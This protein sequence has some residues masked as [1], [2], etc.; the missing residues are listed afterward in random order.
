V[1]APKHNPEPIP[2]VSLEDVQRM[3]DACINRGW[4]TRRDR[5]AII[6]LFDTGVRRSEFVALNLQDIDMDSGAVQVL[7]GKGSKDRVTFFSDM[8]RVELRRYLRGRSSEPGDRPLWLGRDRERMSVEALRG[9]IEHAA[10]RAGLATVPSPH[11]FRRGFAVNMLR[12]GADLLTVSRLLGHESLEVTKRY[13]ALV[14]DDL[15]RVHKATSPAD[16]LKLRR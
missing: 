4:Y 13:L 10:E 5:A 15:S 3:A 12:N 11:D 8:T 6:F 1:Q 2:G 16:R 14:E 9:I 7:N